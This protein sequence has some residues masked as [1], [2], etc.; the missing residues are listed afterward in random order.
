MAENLEE[1]RM[2]NA[3]FTFTTAKIHELF[4]T[5]P[6]RCDLMEAFSV[7]T[8]QEIMDDQ[9]TVGMKLVFHL[10][11]HLFRNE[12][13]KLVQK[14]EEAEPVPFPVAM[15]GPEGCGEIRYIGGWAVRKALKKS[16]NCATSPVV[17]LTS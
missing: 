6:C 16:R 17:H 11:H 2:T 3:K 13:K 8:W 9:R 4:F 12:V 14:Q 15:M 5:N 1:T 10:H 7:Q